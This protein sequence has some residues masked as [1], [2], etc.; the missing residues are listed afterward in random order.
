M[1]IAVEAVV[2]APYAEHTTH[3]TLPLAIVVTLAFDPIPRHYS[4]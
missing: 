1:D 3:T 4:P 2:V